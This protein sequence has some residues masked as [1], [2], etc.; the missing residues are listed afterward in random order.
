MISSF[1]ISK[2]SIYINVQ[3]KTLAAIQAE[4]GADV[5]INGGLYD[6]TKF[7]PVCHLK[8]DGFVYAKDEYSYYG[9]GWNNEDTK[10]QLVSKYDTLDNYICCL[11][12]IKDGQA[13]DLYYDRTSLGGKRGRTAFG[14]MPDGKVAIFCTKD[15][16]ADALTPEALQE[17]LL[18]QG[19]ANA[20]MLDGGGSS[21]CITPDGNITSARIVQNVLCFWFDKDKEEGVTEGMNLQKC[22]LTN[23]KC[24]K[25]GKTIV[26]KGI[27]LHS[28]GAN[29]PNLKRYVQPDDGKLGTNAYGN[30]WNVGNL[31]VCVHAFIGKLKDGSIATYQTLPWNHRGWHGGGSS[32]DTHIGIEICED[33]LTDATYFNKVYRE[34]VELCAY[35]CK[36]YGLDADDIICHSEGYKKGIA[37]N[38]ADVMHWFP[39]HNKSMDTFR[40]EV[41]MKLATTKESKTIYRVQVGAFSVKENAEKLA[42]ELKAKGYSTIIKQD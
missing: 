42:A 23:N 4:T 28:T 22:F 21:Q 5:I 12:L 30:H 18:E 6:M 41:K 15:G 2:A 9:F 26:P 14:T 1:G 29:N 25:E 38:H 24:Y 7:S 40:G 36:M 33:G 32:N 3:R 11:A 35:L 16:T 8:A 10:L 34:A 31:S 20:V 27:M 39:K 17:H 13:L 19:W 37:S